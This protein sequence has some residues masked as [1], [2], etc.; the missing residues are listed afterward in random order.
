MFISLASIFIPYLASSIAPPSL[1]KSVNSNIVDG[2]DND[3]FVNLNTK[4]DY[5]KL[6]Q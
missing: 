2:F 4:D 6:I 3:E 1:I 5:L